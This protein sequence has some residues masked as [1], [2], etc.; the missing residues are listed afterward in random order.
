MLKAAGACIVAKDTKRII[1][2]Q[3]DKYGSHPRNWGFWGGKVENNENIS[4]ALLR[5]VCEEL[6]INIKKDVQKIYPLDQYHS[7]NK[8]FSY[9]SFVIVVKK[10]F[11]PRLNHE[12]G[13]Y[14]WIEHDYFPKPLHPGTRRTLFKKNKLKV[15]REIISSL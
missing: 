4:Q 7:R 2:Q 11:I 3:R 8:D 1:L 5:E 12:S 9:Y 6:G 15:I 13:G 14:A 10:E